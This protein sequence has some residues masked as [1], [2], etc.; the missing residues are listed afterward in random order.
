MET[1]STSMHQDVVTVRVRVPGKVNVALKVGPLAEDGYHPI[2]TIFQAVSLFDELEVRPSDDLSITMHGEGSE[3]L[4]GEQN[5]ALRAARLLQRHHGVSDGAELTIRKTIPVAGGMAGGSADAAG[6][7]LAC[8]ILWDLDTR[9]DELH[10]LAA[11]LG[12]DVPFA[13]MGGVARGSGRGT[14]LVPM[15]T[16]GSYYWVLAM[17]EEGLSTPEVFGRRDELVAEGL[18]TASTRI[19]EPLLEALAAGQVRRVAELLDND[20]QAAAI[21]LRPHLQQVLDAGLAAGAAGAMVSGSGPTCA[22]LAEGEAEAMD[23][24]TA[25]RGCPLVRAV[26]RAVGPA[27]GAWT[28]H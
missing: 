23:L 25:L 16:R 13:L 21:S 4:V 15:L 12:S 10:E 6:A 28:V 18:A 9:P 5:L 26:R 17:A 11:Q 7:L 3:H 24:A 19:P 1:N 2:G 8:S 22:F 27:R 20:L 14:E